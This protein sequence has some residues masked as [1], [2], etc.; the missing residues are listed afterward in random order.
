MDQL[1]LLMHQIVFRRAENGL[2]VWYCVNC[3]S[4]IFEMED[5]IC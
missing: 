3:D 4:E 1:C 5:S 2:Y